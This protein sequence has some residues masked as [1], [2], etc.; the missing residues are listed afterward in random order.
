MSFSRTSTRRF[1][2]VG[3]SFVLTI[4]RTP[5]GF[6]VASNTRESSARDDVVAIDS[7]VE[8]IADLLGE[9]AEGY[10]TSYSFV[11]GGAGS[12]LIHHDP[13]YLTRPFRELVEGT[14][15]VDGDG[16]YFQYVLD[17][18]TKTAINSRLD[19]VGAVS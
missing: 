14:V 18:Q 10:E 7:S 1:Q 5:I 11:T 15:N 4:R 6:S 17:G 19:G 8:E 2:S 9:H 16:G 12:I 13:N 3:E